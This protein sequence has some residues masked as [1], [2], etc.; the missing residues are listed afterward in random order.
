MGFFP[1]IT[2]SLS[3][4]LWSQMLAGSFFLFLSPL[5]PSGSQWIFSQV[6]HNIINLW[7]GTLTG[8]EVGSNPWIFIRSSFTVALIISG[9]LVICHS[10]LIS[11]VLVN[12]SRYFEFGECRHSAYP[13]LVRVGN[14]EEGLWKSIRGALSRKHHQHWVYKLSAKDIWKDERL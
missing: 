12:S 1:F 3:L 7:K 9:I 14:P 4:V 13:L 6:Y 11:R 5:N 10:W 2:A 8:F